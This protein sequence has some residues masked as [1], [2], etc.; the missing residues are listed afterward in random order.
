[1]LPFS[2]DPPW[3]KYFIMR[4]AYAILETVEELE[5]ASYVCRRYGV[6]EIS[7]VLPNLPA[8]GTTAIDAT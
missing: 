4:K 7:T 3:V 2:F 1:M 5:A 8:G 6:I